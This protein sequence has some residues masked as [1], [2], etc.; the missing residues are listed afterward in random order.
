MYIHNICSV[1]VRLDLCLNL[2]SLVVQTTV[3][4]SEKLARR[5]DM[6]PG[7]IFVGDKI[8]LPGTYCRQNMCVASPR[9]Q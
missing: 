3:A 4:K 9:V 1:L 6:Q 5:R 2:L 8:S 7:D